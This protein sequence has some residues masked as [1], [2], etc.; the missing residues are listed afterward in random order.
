MAVALSLADKLQEEP[1]RNLDVWVVL[2]G[3]EECG[4]EGMR[5]FARTH[6]DELDPFKTIVLAIDSVGKGDVRWV[7]AEGMTISFE[8]DAR[9][10]QLCEAIAEADREDTNRY[11]AAALRHG[12]ATD[13]LAA[14][15][16]GLRAST[17]TCLEPGA[18]TPANYHTPQ[19]VPDAIDPQAMK[20]AA[21]FTL[22]L[23]RALDR[24]L[25][26]TSKRTPEPEAESPRP[27]ARRAR[28]RRT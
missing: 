9:V 8:M 28:R 14:R 11:R 23:I 22:D 24:D 21:N 20:R 4:L 19:D 10:G 1:P 12:F 16:A 17:I 5:S 7:T 6:K 25:A 3:G 27:R 26:R 18:I 15:V 13:A 2:T